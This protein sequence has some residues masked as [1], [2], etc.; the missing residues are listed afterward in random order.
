VNDNCYN[1]EHIN[2]CGNVLIEKLFCSR[3]MLYHGILEFFY[4]LGY[5]ECFLFITELSGECASEVVIGKVI[6]IFT[7]DAADKVPV[8]TFGEEK[9]EDEDTTKPVDGV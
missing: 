3:S 1:I 9:N 5:L 2:E 8:I 4:L 7:G 6:V